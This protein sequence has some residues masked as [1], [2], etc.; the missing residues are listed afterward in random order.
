MFV[1]SGLRATG[2]TF[3]LL[4]AVDDYDDTLYVKAQKGEDET[5]KDYIEFLRNSKEKNII[6]D[7]Y[8]WI[9]DNRDLS[10]YLWTLGDI[11]PPLTEVGASC[12][13][14]LILCDLA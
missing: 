6:I 1:L 14:S 5:G 11:L 8:T 13:T 9:K 10:Y 4:Q 3:G 2:K 7:E 12:L